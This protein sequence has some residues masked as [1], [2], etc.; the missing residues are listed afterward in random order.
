MLQ[1]KVYE[2]S[3]KVIADQLFLDLYETEPIKLNISIED[4]TSTDATSVFSRTFKV[5]ATRNNEKFFKNAFMVQGIT[6]DITV[7]KPAEIL[8]DGAE[9]KTGHIRLQKIFVNSDMDK[10]EYELLFLGETRD[11]SSIIG[12]APLCQIIMTDFNWPGL[13][14][15]YTDSLAY[16]GTPTYTNITNSWEAFPES[17]LASNLAGTTGYA[18]GNIIFPLIDHGNTYNSSG[19]AEQGVITLDQNDSE[20]FTRSQDAIAEGRMKPMVRAKRIWDQIFETSGY[21]YE[22]SFLDSERFQQIYISAFGNEDSVNVNVQQYTTTN[23]Q[24]S[25]TTSTQ[26]WEDWLTLDDA[27]YNPGGYYNTTG[28]GTGQGSYFDAPAGSAVPSPYYIMSGSADIDAYIENSDF[29]VTDIPGRLELW[30]TNPGVPVVV[31]QG[32][33]VTNGVS[34][35]YWDSRNGGVQ[36]ATGDELQLKI[37]R[38]GGLGFDYSE[39][40]NITWECT[41]APGSYYLPQDFDC[42]YKQIDFIKDILTSFRLVMQPAPNTPNHFIIEPWQDFI[43]SGDNFDW[44]DKLVKNKDFVIEPLFNT[45]SQTIE[46]TMQEDEDYI[47]VFHQDNNKHAY[48]YLEFDSNNELLKGKRDITIENISPTPLDQ[49]Q[50]RS[51]QSHPEPQFVVPQVHKHE[52]EG[53]VT[54]HIPI[55]P[56]TRMLFYN[57]LQNIIDNNQHDWYLLNASSPIRQDQ[58]PLV[59]SYENWPVTSNSLNLNFYNDTRYYIDPSPGVAYFAQGATLFDE[60]WSRYINSLYNKFS[61]RVT[62]YFVLDNVDLQNLTFDD[63]IFVNGVYYRPEKIIDAVV[64]DKTE[65]KVQLITLL[66]VKP[67]WTTGTLDFFNAF[68]VDPNCPGEV[69]SIV[70]NTCGTP[71]FTWT[72]SNGQSGVYNAPVGLCTGA[73]AAYSWIINSVPPGSYTL[74]VTDSVGRSSTTNITVTAAV[75]TPIQSTN[76]VSNPTDCAP[77]PCNGEISV[78]PSGGTGPYTILWN[79]GNTD[80]SRTDLCEGTYTYTV[81]DSLGCSGK[82]VINT[83]TCEAPVGTTHHWVNIIYDENCLEQLGLNEAWTTDGVSYAPGTIADLAGLNGC[84]YMLDNAPGTANTTVNSTGLTC[85][86]CGGGPALE[87]PHHWVE[88]QYDE[89]CLE[90]LVDNH[91]FTND[92]VSYAPGTIARLAGSPRCWYMLDNAIGTPRTT[93]DSTGLT[94]EQCGGG[95]PGEPYLSVVEYSAGCNISEQA[96]I[97]VDPNGLPWNFGDFIKVGAIC[98]EILGVTADPPVAVVD[99]VHPD[100]PSCQAG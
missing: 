22:S 68:G 11:F 52:G 8:V 5:P 79:D 25:E 12:D 46:F 100:C 72:L 1:I 78:T 89:N 85:E 96:P 23:F 63:V 99:S 30:R 10:I 73:G 62:A 57:G 38:S 42:Q 26:Q 32:N 65:V 40:T 76:I 39:V 34:S 51:G 15:D 47:N 88:I 64:G 36:L 3:N 67:K 48:G 56:N 91:L 7:K 94:C 98:Y 44:S 54:E 31:A 90:S 17:T 9:F 33:T 69:G 61:R 83:I 49:I 55:K 16:T 70:V 92:L 18:N 45:Q 58:W 77:A 80:F 4:I 6:F 21:T 20:R 95:T 37:V 41:A 71:Q 93:V 24:A 82:P 2:D 66:D 53:G 14:V 84:W 87:T 43:G 27:V 81:S 29:T 86:Q 13:P 59:S 28:A 19:I 35:F 74:T 97:V 75:G 50:Q 60:Y